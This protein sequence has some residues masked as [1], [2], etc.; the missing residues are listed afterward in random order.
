MRRYVVPA[1]LAVPSLFALMAYG[2]GSTEPPIE[3]LCGWLQDPNNCYREFGRDIRQTGITQCTELSGTTNAIPQVGEFQGRDKLDVCIL[4]EGGLITFD[5][6]VDLTMLPPAEV[7]FKFINA[8]QTEC[9]GVDWLAD[10]SFSFTVNGSLVDDAGNAALQGVKGG[11][12]SLKPTPSDAPAMGGNGGKPPNQNATTTATCPSGESHYF[13]TLEVKKC[14]AYEAIQP[15]ASLKLIQGGLD[16]DGNPGGTY[17]AIQFSLFL[18]PTDGALINAKPDEIQFFTCLFP[19]APPICAN[20]IQDPGETDIDCGGSFCA[21]RCADKQKC[22][23]GA[24]C[25]SAVCTP[26]KGIKQ[27]IGGAATGSTGAGGAGGGGGAGGAGSTTS[28]TGTGM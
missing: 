22:I 21:T 11:T 6:P 13:N 4:R 28:S 15:R 23:T 9:G 16:K 2:C 18:P 27:C 17:G 10:D 8:N 5:T 24:D 20:G 25:A 19:A 14:T 26:V 12:F 3:D 7:A 1:L